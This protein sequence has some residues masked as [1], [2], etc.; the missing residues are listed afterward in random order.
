MIMKSRQLVIVVALLLFNIYKT[1]G[2]LPDPGRG[3]Y[4]DRFFR[5]VI[6]S[7]TVTID[8]NYSIL[9]IPSKEDALLQY[10]MDN[11]IT[12]L[13]LYDI[14]KVFNDPDYSDYYKDLLCS[15][16]RKA[17]TQYCIKLIGVN[18]ACASLFSD[19]FGITASPAYILSN[20]NRSNQELKY[21]E[22]EYSPEDHFEFLKSE[23]TKLM[24]RSADFNDY[25]DAK[26]DVFL[27]EYE[28]WYPKADDCYG[29]PSQNTHNLYIQFKALVQAIDRVRDDYNFIHS[30]QVYSEAYIGLFNDG[31]L[32]GETVFHQQ[33]AD[34]LD[35]VYTNSYGHI[36]RQLDRINTVYYGR[37]AA[38]LYNLYLTPEYYTNRFLDLNGPNNN[39]R[40]NM[41]PIFSAEYAPYATGGP[42]YYGFW[43]SQDPRNTI[44]TAEK[45]WFNSFSIDANINS[46]PF[47]DRCDIYPGG[48]IWFAQSSLVGH[49]DHPQLFTS[50]SPICLTSGSTT[51]NPN[52][53]YIGPIEQGTSYKFYITDQN[54]E[55]KLYNQI[56]NCLKKS[57]M[58]LTLVF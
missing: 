37:D 4:V 48:D 45:L 5:P 13:I 19:N 28:F 39:Q 53:Q 46:L 32:A 22:N 54:S 55:V 18:S 56:L 33:V 30:H 44:F 3:L 11:D 2:Q 1:M 49:Q 21:V 24:L 36:K 27:T 31:G 12:Y 25:C 51:A 7:G 50:N 35:G 47:E 41:D 20:H 26:V 10:A 16:I 29:G 9:G 15:F 17:K 52:F 38:I 8:P 23:V 43:F 34:W 14:G 58:Y 57:A 40:T 42:N 6:S